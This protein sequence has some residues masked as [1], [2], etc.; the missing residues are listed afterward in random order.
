[1]EDN[2][3]RPKQIYKGLNSG[4]GSALED[5]SER[6]KQI[7]KGLKSGQGSALELT[8]GLDVRGSSP[9]GYKRFFP[10]PYPSGIFLGPTRSHAQ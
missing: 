3:E 7:Y 8:T 5:N 4:Q 9:S 6:P 1:M 10:P 2:S